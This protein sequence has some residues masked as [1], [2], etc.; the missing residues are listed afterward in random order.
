M[1]NKLNQR[2]SYILFRILLAITL[3]A[4]LVLSLSVA[5][6]AYTQDL[7]VEITDFIVYLPNPDKPEPKRLNL[8]RTQ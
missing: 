1:S 6:P 8:R 7:A 3:A 4:G 2:K 5:Q